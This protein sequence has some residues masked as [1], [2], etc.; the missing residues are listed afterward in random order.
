MFEWH[1]SYAT[2]L[3]WT[4]CLNIQGFQVCSTTVQQRCKATVQQWE[5]SS[6]SNNNQDCMVRIVLFYDSFDG[7]FSFTSQP[8]HT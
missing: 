2:S 6:I 1:Q 7:R 3:I 8:V 5:L 4:G